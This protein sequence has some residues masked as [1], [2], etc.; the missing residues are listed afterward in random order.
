MEHKII[1][2]AAVPEDYDQLQSL[3]QKMIEAE[4][5]FDHTI[6][7]EPTYYYDLDELITD[8][9]TELLVAVVDSKVIATGYVQIRT[10]REAYIHQQY[11]YVGFI[12]VDEEYRGHG[13]CQQ[14]IERLVQWGKSKDLTHYQLDVFSEN[15][16][17]IRAYEK[18]GFRTTLHKMKLDVS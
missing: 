3:E 4:R 13:L 14:I 2:R 11:G 5:P 7:R 18:L 8:N 17:A 9:D 6:K 12:Y 1:I 16:S 15:T 10:A